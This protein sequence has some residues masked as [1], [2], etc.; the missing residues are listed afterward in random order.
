MPNTHL[1]QLNR[2]LRSL[3]I[4]L[5]LTTL[6]VT[7]FALQGESPLMQAWVVHK[8]TTIPW[9]VIEAAEVGTGVTIPANSH[10][11]FHLPD[12]F[13]KINR[14]V[15][16]GLSGERTRYWG[17]C[18]PAN[19]D[20]ARVDKREGF[21]GLLFLS[22]KEQAIRRAAAERERAVFPLLEL[23]TKEEADRLQYRK[24]EKIR[25][26]VEVFYP[27]SM[28]YIM[29]E[30][31]LALGLDPDAD[32]LNSKL[33]QELTTNATLADTD[34]DGISDGIEYTSTTSPTLR[35]SD[36]D[37][38]IDGIED[39][40]WNGRIDAGESDPRMWDTDRDGLC[41]GMC[42]VRLQNRQYVYTGEDK[43]LNGI[44]DT[45]E[46]SPVKVDTDGDEYSD[47]VEYLQC[48]ANGKNGC[49]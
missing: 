34:G 29:T 3:T 46:T 14:E 44:L 22:E 2:T 36:S 6:V 17:Y 19:Y 8:T 32:R 49:Q 38:L 28:C 13:T 26:Q 11:A 16:L 7:A 5:G 9:V 40:N 43:N 15:L 42:R 33:E 31:P 37:G 47:Q 27:G 20:P 25:H 48:L 12:T 30:A 18:F 41:D 35:D 23:P 4:S 45:G 24:I 21:P 10:V 1:H 39:A